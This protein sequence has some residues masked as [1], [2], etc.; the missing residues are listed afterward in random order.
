MAVAVIAFKDGDPKKVE[1]LPNFAK[2]ELWIV[3]VDLPRCF[4]RPT[5]EERFVARELT[6]GSR[7]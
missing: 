7:T 3:V 5:A 6:R 2:V 1:H 4:T